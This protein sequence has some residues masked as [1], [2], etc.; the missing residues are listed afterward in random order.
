M[1]ADG[2]FSLETMDKLKGNKLLPDDVLN[3]LSGNVPS[4]GGGGA[5]PSPSVIDQA[6]EMAGI[7]KGSAASNVVDNLAT[8]AKQIAGSAYDKGK[9]LFDQTPQGKL[10]ND[11]KSLYSGVAK[12]VTG[13]SNLASGLTKPN[14]FDGQQSANIGEGGNMPVEPGQVNPEDLALSAPKVDPV[15]AFRQNQLQSMGSLGDAYG[16][17]QSAALQGAQAGVRQANAEASYLG[18]MQENLEQKEQERATLEQDRQARLDGQLGK[19]N[20]AVNAFSAMPKTLQESFDKMGTGQKIMTGIALFLGAAPNST[21][22]NKAVTVMQDSLDKTIA[23]QKSDI[24]NKETVLGKM[25]SMF[26]DERQAEAAARLAYINNAQIKM[27]QIASQYKGPQ[28]EANAKLLYGQLEAAKQKEMA[29]FA[30]AA[31]V[32]PTALGADEMTKKIMTLPKELQ[33]QAFEEKGI[34]ENLQKA[35]QNIGEAFDKIGGTGYISS[36]VP[37]STNRAAVQAAKSAIM[38]AVQANWKGPMSDTDLLRID[39]LM[40]EESDTPKQ[41]ESIKAEMLK[42]LDTNA[43]P[44]PMLQGFGLKPVPFAKKYNLKPL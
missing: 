1:A 26:G 22:Q 9:F 21:G 43:K 35:K 34:Y 30:K 28:I 40:P 24:N 31:Q 7:Q 16:L 32:N 38:A 8:G 23:A 37:F 41:I 4:F 11:A 25:R 39:G 10:V 29:A 3:Q 17:Q 15:D 33:K 36:K 18:K 12:G 27:Q 13:L 20:E 44:T 5:N 2:P 14:Y 6:L 19:L 42:V